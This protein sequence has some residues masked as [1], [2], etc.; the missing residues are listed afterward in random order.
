MGN[1]DRMGWGGGGYLL[2]PIC[3]DSSWCSSIFGGEDVPFLQLG[4]G[5]LKLA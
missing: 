2:R 5:I 4:A 1:C 3:S